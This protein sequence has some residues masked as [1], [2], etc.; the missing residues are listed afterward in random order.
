MRVFFLFLLILN[1]LIGGWFYLQPVKNNLAVE[2]MDDNINALV[3]INEVNGQKKI[4]KALVAVK[5]VAIKEG[6]ELDQQSVKSCH[7]LGPFK[8]ERILK[9]ARKQLAEQVRDIDVRKR[10]ESQRHRYWVYLPTMSSRAKAI[11]Q[12]K[13]LAKY[14]ISD[15]YI[16]HS[17]DKRNAISL[18]HFKEKKHADHRVN[19]L[20]KHDLEAEMEVIF[21]HLDV[22]WL[23]YSTVKN[24]AS[25]DE[26][27]SEF[28]VDGVTRLDRSCK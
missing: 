22:F 8:D 3:L 10:E 5:P 12:S 28:M 19:Q 27:V 16:V 15:Y 25:N 24:N 26:M 9:Q 7:T 20:K 6:V 1:G 18:G 14:K 23:D 4:K 13:Q 11:E 17:G 2:P 21:R